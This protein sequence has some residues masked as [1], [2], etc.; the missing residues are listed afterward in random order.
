MPHANEE[1]CSQGQQEEVVMRN[2]KSGAKRDTDVGKPDYEG[3]LNPLVLERFGQY[4]LKHQVQADG[5]IRDSDNWQRGIPQDVYMK[6]GF[7]HFMDWWKSH[8]T[9]SG[10][11]QE[12]LCALIF[13][14]MGYLLAL[15]EHKEEQKNG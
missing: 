3:Y 15:V 11:C 1:G 10:D 12:A 5:A 6:S 7:R 2:F 9:G 13:N 8:R 4:M 14:A